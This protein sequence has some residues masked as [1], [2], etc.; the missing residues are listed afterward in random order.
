[1]STLKSDKLTEADLAQYRDEGYAIVRGLI[2]EQL[3]LGIR[4]TLQQLEAGEYEGWPQRSFQFVD[5]TSATCPN[6]MPLPL[7][8]QQPAAHSE[9]FKAVADHPELQAAMST[10]LGGP[11][12]RFTDQAA[13]KSKLITTEQAGRSYY[14]QDSFYWRI[15]PE[16]GCNV[17]I[18]TCSVG[19]DAIALAIKPGTHKSWELVDHE[20]YE[21]DPAWGHMQPGGSFKALRRHRIP[22]SAVDFSNEVIIEAEPGD[23]IFFSNFT[24]HRSEPNNSGESKEFYAIAYRRSDVDQARIQ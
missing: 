10:L 8:V 15:A 5:P 9:V 19:R 12:C 16:H 3:M 11:V 22:T 17:W 4:E 1:M 14:H 23:A 24:W 2:P 18:P 21:D 7:G 20:N 13:I 6:G